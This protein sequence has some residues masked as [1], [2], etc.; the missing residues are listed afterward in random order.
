MQKLSLTNKYDPYPEYKDSGA[1]WIGSIPSTWNKVSFRGFVKE[2]REKNINGGNTN[3][4]S[5]SY[6]KI[7]NKD[8][9]SNGGLLPESF[10]TYQV[11][12]KGN[13]VLR[14]TDLQNDKKSLRVGFVEQDNGIITSA[15]LGL[16]ITDDF[17][18]RFLYH[19]I[20]SYDLQKVFYNLGAGV[21]QTLDYKNMKYLPLLLPPKA[22][23]EK[24]A[25]FLDVQTA[26][27]DETI[28]KKQKL[29]ELLK[30]KRTAVIN[31]AVTKGLD[32][33]VELVESGIDWIG[34]IP[35]SWEVKKLKHYLKNLDGKR[36][37]LS[38]DERTKMQGEYPYYGA[39]GIIDYVNGYL[40]E[41]DLILISEDG[42]N[43]LN[44]ST[45][46]SFIANGKYWVNN[47][48]HIAK[49]KDGFLDFWSERVEQLDVSIFTSGSAQPKLTIHSLQNICISAPISIL[50]RKMI[51]EFVSNA[52]KKYDTPLKKVNESISKLQELKSSL[53]SHAVTGKIKV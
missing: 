30:E 16:K 31:H 29:V 22:D 6:G 1:E 37:P 35:R 34:K 3:L 25:R 40:F 5:L 33:E 23:Q 52:R 19:L 43:L 45:P 11:V 2:N 24:I 4:L 36:I 26:R 17:S 14:L 10:N 46:I 20:H 28:A 12:H 9:E 27:I 13:L 47:H 18:H 21:R 32:S 44:R 42:A 50:E 41:E 15:Y 49:P 39:S 8:I 48:A 7:I 53:I 51:G 38:T